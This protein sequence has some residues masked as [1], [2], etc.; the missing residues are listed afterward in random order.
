LTYNGFYDDNLEFVNLEN[1]Q[2]VGS[3]NPSNTL[4]RH[5]LSTRFTSIVR[6]CSINYPT[7][8]Q[9]Q[10]I[11]GNYLQAILQ[12]QLPNHKIWSSTSKTNQLALSMIH[13]YDELRTK[14]N[15]DEHSHYLFTP[16]DLTRWCLSFLRYDLS[17]IKG[18]S[19]ADSLLEIWTYEACRLFKDRLV[20]NDARDKFDQLLDK[21]L[22]SDWSSSALSALRDSYFVSWVNANNRRT[23]PPAGR[24]LSRLTTKDLTPFI[25]RGITRYRSDYRDTDVFLFREII[26]AIVRCDRVLTSPGGSLLLAGR[27][28]VGR[29]TAVGIV[30]SMNNMK[31]Y[32]PKV[33]RSYGIKQFK[34]DLK[35]ILQNAGVEGEQCVL[36]MEDYQFIEPTFVELINSLLSAGE[37]PGLYSPDELEAILSPLREDSSQE[38]FRGTMV[39]YFAQRVKTN[40]HIVLIMDF[41]RPTFTTACQS[42]PGFFKECA[43]QWTEG[44]S[45]RSLV[46]IPSMLF[47]KDH[48]DEKGLAEK[49]TFDDELAKLFTYI[50]HSMDTKYHTP[51]RYLS[52]LETYRQV[53]VTKQTAIIKRQKHLKSGVSKLND[54]RKVVDDLRRNAEYKQKELAIKQQEADDALKQITKSMAVSID[55]KCQ[56]KQTFEEN[57]FF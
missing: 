40:L 52:L 27:S 49:F 11:Y 57:R 30:A 14:F 22:R 39:Q 51:R 56:S 38:N 10:L 3:M 46:K 55:P 26:D 7:N 17:G 16:R 24:L 53:Y 21:T 36:L 35:T 44:W 37:I 6:L 48:S 28:G 45:E 31:L 9:L 1:I 5:K 33:S 54:A 29:R 13:V 23:L 50:Y 12:Q 4:G 41:T 2:I 32:S 19:N 20:G 43:V 47:S 18:D 42:N 15:Q 8:D 25:D 34:N